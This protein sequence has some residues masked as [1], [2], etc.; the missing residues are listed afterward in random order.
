[1][2]DYFFGACALA[3]FMFFFGGIGLLI[4]QDTESRTC[5]S[6]YVYLDERGGG[7]VPWEVVYGD[8]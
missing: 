7:C 2:S 8:R 5:E 1:M 6:G 3:G 4:W